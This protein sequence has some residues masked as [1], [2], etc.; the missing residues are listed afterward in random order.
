M[1]IFECK[2]CRVVKGQDPAR[3][4]LNLNGK[5]LPGIARCEIRRLHID[6]KGHQCISSRIE[7][8]LVVFIASLVRSVFGFSEA[9]IAVPL[10]ALQVSSHPDRGLRW[11]FLLSVAIATRCPRSGLAQDSSRQYKRGYLVP[12]RSPEDPRRNQLLT[13]AHQDL[14][15]GHARCR[16]SVLFR[17]SLCSAAARASGPRQAGHGSWAADSSQ[18]VLGG[19]Y[20]MNGLLS[21]SMEPCDAGRRNTSRDPAGLL[22]SRKCNRSRRVRVLRSVGPSPITHYFL[23]SLIAAIPATLL[24]SRINR[25]LRRRRLF[26]LRLHWPY[27][28][29]YRPSHAGP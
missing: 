25:R 1:A 19:A 26:A 15:Q 8:L 2:E 17:L 12:Q 22:P 10:L 9:L 13:F 18:A 27:L 21:S 3:C 20:G 28:H 29:R 24:G 4:F 6:T 7:I 23:V 14:H 11:P 5:E 16:D